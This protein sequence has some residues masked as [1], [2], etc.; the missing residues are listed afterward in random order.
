M[1]KICFISTSNSLE[2]IPYDAEKPNF[3][4]IK[5]AEEEQELKKLFTNPYVYYA[6]TSRGCSCD[7]TISKTP[8]D[9]TYPKFWVFIF[10]LLGILDKKEKQKKE[11]YK[12][13]LLEQAKHYK[14]TL[15]LFELIRQNCQKDQ[16]VE[17]YCCWAGGEKSPLI[18]R[19]EGLD[20]SE[21]SLSEK[22]HLE[23]ENFLVIKS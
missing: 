19:V 23:E 5:V 15:A 22:F 16:F 6:G 14:D 18:K 9:W 20:L 11:G 17:L 7:F 4:L 1:C 3:C 2:E 13:L 10:K 12:K 8:R 21:N